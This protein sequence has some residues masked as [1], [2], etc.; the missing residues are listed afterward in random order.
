VITQLDIPLVKEGD[1]KDSIDAPVSKYQ[2][3]EEVKARTVAVMERF[4]RAVQVTTKPYDEFNNIS[5]ITRMN[6]DQKLFNNWKE[7]KSQDPDES[8][9][10]NAV[11]PIVRN[12]TIS[13]AAHLTGQLIEPGIHAQNENQDE[14][15]DAST[16]M[17]GLMDWANEQAEYVKTFVYAVIA[18]L[19]NPASIIHTE[20]AEHYRTIKEIQEDGTWKKKE[21]LDEIMSGFRDT[22]VPLDELFIADAYVHDIQKQPYLFWRKA[23]N[24]TEA[25]VEYGQMENWK[26]V[27][28]G[29]Q[30]YFDQSQGSFYEIYD[31]SLQDVLVEKVIYYDR[32]ND[33][34]LCFINGVLMN[35]VDQPN[36][37]KDKMYPFIKGGYE[38]I[39]E[40]KFFYYFSLVRKMADD[41]EIINTLYRMIIDGTFLKVM[42][43]TAIMG[44]VVINSAVMVPRKMTTIG[45]AM[46]MESLGVQSDLNSG[47]AT[48][49]KLESSVSESSNDVQQ[50]GLTNP[51]DKTAFQVSVEEKNAAIVGGIV[52]RMIGFMVRDWMKLRVGDIVQ[53]LTVG[54]I[55]E[56]VGDDATLKYRSFLLP[57]KSDNGKKVSH[58]IMLD[59]ESQYSPDHV[60]AME[61]GAPAGEVQGMDGITLSQY[62]GKGLES[63]QR[64][65]ITNPEI[66]RELKY[67]I[68]VTPD[69]EKPVSE[70]LNRAL[71]LEE[72][73]RAIAS[74]FANQQALYQDLLLG[75][76]SK[77]KDD[78]EKY[79]SQPQPQ[80]GVPQGAPQG[81]GSSVLGKL[82][83]GQQMQNT[84][85]AGL[86]TKT[87]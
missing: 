23:I 57:N 66:F 38:L 72:Y 74:P 35:D 33:L 8:W 80:M 41:A 32:Y 28:P 51:N 18:A 78:V 69:I 22:L 11:R 19:V 70:A 45:E 55:D 84:A 86:P 42:P 29:Y 1:A 87:A 24:Y 75:S 15:K 48:L 5:L 12:R 58:K 76:Y 50:A 16:V 14:D 43:P 44:D 36:P 52:R 60:L 56:I 10:S 39:D 83:G 34:Q 64:I 77:T 59:P 17:R 37:R 6:T 85:S 71:N 47:F 7:P 27:K 21:V 4:A 2:P 63:D 67:K 3:S 31:Q 13:I 62:M 40:G 82:F 25:A 68:V 53:F 20:Y 54:E 79:T 46:K 65:F 61:G 9:Q 49:E 30:A 81:Q 73:D 26:Y